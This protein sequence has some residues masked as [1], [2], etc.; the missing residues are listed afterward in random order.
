M[1]SCQ[2][3]GICQ[4]HGGPR[5]PCY[6][7]VCSHAGARQ[8]L[9]QLSHASENMVHL[10]KESGL[11]SPFPHRNLQLVLLRYHLE[12]SPTWSYCFTPSLRR[13]LRP[14]SNP[15]PRAPTKCLFQLD[16]LMAFVSFVYGPA[17]SF[18]PTRMFVCKLV[19]IHLPRKI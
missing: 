10:R 16:R 5:A 12:V 19:W 18:Q 11:D 8:E 4:V 6:A 7:R 13:R 15:A 2:D 17:A 1:S 9:S 14:V 3:R